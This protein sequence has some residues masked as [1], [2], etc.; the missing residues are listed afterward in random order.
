MIIFVTSYTQQVPVIEAHG[1]L[2]FIQSINVV[3]L[4]SLHAYMIIFVIGYHAI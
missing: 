1:Q 2:G 3:V 4:C